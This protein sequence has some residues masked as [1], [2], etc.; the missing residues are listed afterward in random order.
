MIDYAGFDDTLLVTVCERFLG[1]HKVIDIVEWLQEEHGVAIKR[2]NIY[3]LLREARK[4]G[5]LSVHPPPDGLLR[6]RICDRFDQKKDNVHVLRVRGETSR[7]HVADAA[8]E[9]IVKLIH[10]V[11]E[12]KKR[13][14]IG[15]GGGGTIMEASRA[16]AS[17][18]RSESSLP[19]LA[20]HAVT[21][22]FDVANPWTA[23]VCFLA[24]FAEAAPNI[25]YVGLF[26]PPAVEAREY[27][28]AKSRPGVAE[29]FRMAKDIDIV[30]TSM[31]SAHDEHGEL[32]RFMNFGGKKNRR[33]A[34]LKKSGWVGDVI[35]HPYAKSG[36]IATTEGMRAVSLFDLE[37]LIALAARPK[38][39]VV[40]VV[41]PCG[42]CGKSKGNALRPL[43]ENRGL[44]LWS[45]LFLDLTTAQ[46]LL[47]KEDGADGN[48]HGASIPSAR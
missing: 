2:E 40:L 41:A 4:R 32:N 37:D 34:S 48:G 31:A 43:L 9:L 28:H 42:I 19:D 25:E 11:G 22:G 14:R 24:Y 13:V 15:L 16:L 45:H 5:Y 47:P 23:P 20:L 38:K 3:P 46:S 30:V 35:Y 33:L 21:S 27:E 1:E 7:D 39:H 26:A 29:S 44:K 17:R 18:L 8:A 12:D 36:P 6:Q 10:E